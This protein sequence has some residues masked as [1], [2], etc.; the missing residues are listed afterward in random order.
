MYRYFNRLEKNSAFDAEDLKKKKADLW[1]MFYKLKKD[2]AETHSLWCHLH[3]TLTIAESVRHT[4][5]I[6]LINFF[7]KV[8]NCPQSWVFFFLAKR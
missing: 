7:I 3:R 1:R 2:R 4:T 8:S 6:K 5:S